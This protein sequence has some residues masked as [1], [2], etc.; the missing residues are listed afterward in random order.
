MARKSSRAA[1]V[2]TQEQRVTLK[3]LAGSRTAPHQEIERAKV[4][5]GYADGTSITQ[6]GRLDGTTL[7]FADGDICCL[8]RWKS[9]CSACRAAM[10]WSS[11]SP[12]PAM[13]RLS[14]CSKWTCATA[15][16]VVG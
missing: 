14:W 15:Y 10:V 4:L 5:L 2:L 8:R 6:H 9:M 7:E 12:Q 13:W 1:L 3:E 11:P 16:V